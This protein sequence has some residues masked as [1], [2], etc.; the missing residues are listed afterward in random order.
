MYYYLHMTDSTDN[1]KQ[2]INHLFSMDEKNSVENNL[3]STYQ[4]IIP[5]PNVVLSFSE[6]QKRMVLRY[7]NHDL[8][9]TDSIIEL[10]NIEYFATPIDKKIEYDDLFIL[11]SEELEPL[12][13][14][15][16]LKT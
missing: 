4:A 3:D 16:R 14:I 7:V 10:N 2:F 5:D 6:K 15:F 11:K 13:L 12:E 8:S 9:E 1:Y